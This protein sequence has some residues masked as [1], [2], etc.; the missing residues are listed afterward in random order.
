MN[1][2]IFIYCGRCR[3]R[4]YTHSILFLL[5]VPAKGKECVN[6]MI[7]DKIVNLFNIVLHNFNYFGCQRGS[8]V[9]LLEFLYLFFLMHILICLNVELQTDNSKLLGA[10]YAIREVLIANEI[11]KHISSLFHQ[12]SN[13]YLSYYTG[14]GHHQIFW[15]KALIFA[16]LQCLNP[17][18]NE[19]IEINN[20]VYIYFLGIAFNG[21][22]KINFKI[23]QGSTICWPSGRPYI[24]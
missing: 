21:T 4:T 8:R 22:N 14:F 19:R 16:K 15:D 23:V 7:F 10:L 2:S 11:E 24:L 20:I 3:S 13:C 1:K 5:P 17:I 18:V 9:S 12:L 6:G